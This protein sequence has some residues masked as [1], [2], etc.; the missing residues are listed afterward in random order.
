MLSAVAAGKR[1]RRAAPRGRFRAGYCSVAAPR[2]EWLPDGLRHRGAAVVCGS[3][4]TFSGSVAPFAIQ[5][6]E[7]PSMI[8][9]FSIFF[10]SLPFLFGLLR[11]ATTSNDF[12]YLWVAAASLFGAAV[13]TAAAGGRMRRLRMAL[14]LSAGSFVV[15]TL[16]AT[17]AGVLQGTHFGP[18]LLVVAS[19]FAFS[20]AV[21]CTLFAITRR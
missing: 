6:T 15:A 17:A 2:G 19:S 21:G 12:R 11:A 10:L 9:S 5:S 3:R 13:F 4:R 1:H 20:C 7:R 18:G 14:T 16:L 8:R